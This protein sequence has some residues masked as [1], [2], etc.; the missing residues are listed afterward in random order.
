MQRGRARKEREIASDEVGVS[1]FMPSNEP[2]YLTHDE[3]GLKLLVERGS[4][5]PS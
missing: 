1:R 5:N 3:S 4:L 2:S